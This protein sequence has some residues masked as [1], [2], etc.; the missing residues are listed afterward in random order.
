ME[1]DFKSAKITVDI[2][3]SKAGTGISPD[4]KLAVL[5]LTRNAD[6]IIAGDETASDVD[7]SAINIRASV[8]V[9]LSPGDQFS[10][11]DNISNLKF[12]FIQLALH[13]QGYTGWA[14]FS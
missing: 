3:V 12:R 13:M 7:A 4:R 8:D 10:P 6:P 1:I 2:K 14:G 9:H 11:G 5:H